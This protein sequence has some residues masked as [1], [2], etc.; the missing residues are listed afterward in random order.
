MAF[1]SGDIGGR[2]L[3]RKRPGS[4]YGTLLGFTCPVDRHGIRLHRLHRSLALTD[5]V[6]NLFLP[7]YNPRLSRGRD[8]NFIIPAARAA[9]AS[10]VFH[11]AFW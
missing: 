10:R 7:P 8:D 5:G 11:L 4:T 3:N 2:K 6:D 1:T 9:G